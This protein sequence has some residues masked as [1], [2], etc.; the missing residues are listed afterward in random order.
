MVREYGNLAVKI[1]LL[2]IASRK[3][4]YNPFWIGCPPG[5]FLSYKWNGPASKDYVQQIHDYLARLGYHVFFDKNELAEDADGYTSVPEYIANVAN[6]QYYM[7]ILTEKTADYITARTGKTSWIFDE[8]Q[9]ALMLVNEGRMFIV[10]LLVEE[11]GQTDYFTKQ[12][13]ID[14]T[15]GIYNF[16]KLDALFYPVNFKI[17]SATKAIFSD[18]LDGFDVL[19]VQQRWQDAKDFFQQSIAFKNFPD[20]QFR[21]L[22]HS[23][24]NRDIQ[25]VQSSFNYCAD[26]VEAAHIPH[27]LRGYASIYNM[28]LLSANLQALKILP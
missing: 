19:L 10:P 9:Q 20:Y 13:C 15:A 21:L 26:F 2:G 24:C 12:N 11:K 7:L 4:L 5:V 3:K 16:Q 27:L 18:V 23:I 8:Y 22:I 1:A 14:I 25:T 6:C 28:S 17:D